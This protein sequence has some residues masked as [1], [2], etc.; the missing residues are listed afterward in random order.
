MFAQHDEV[1]IKLRPGGD[2]TIPNN[3][4]KTIE[5]WAKLEDYMGLFEHCEIMLRRGLLDGETFSLIFSYRLHNIVA[6][7]IIVDA[8]LRR[9]RES[10]QAFLRLL[11]RLKIDVPN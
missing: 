6:N 5:D 2:W 1:H 9:E 11:E 7:R 10:W 8:K 3:G 4:P